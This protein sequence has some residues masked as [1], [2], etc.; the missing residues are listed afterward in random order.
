MDA[1]IK[2][3]KWSRFLIEEEIKDDKDSKLGDYFTIK[4]GIATGNNKFFIFPKEELISLGLP[5]EEF[6]PIL[7]S[8]RYLEQDII[9]PYDN[10][11]PKLNVELFVLDSKL[12]LPEIAVCYPVLYNYLQKGMEAEIHEGHLCKARKIW[13]SQENRVPRK[14][15]CTYIGRKSNS[16]KNPFRF[17]SNHS[18]AIAN[19]SYLFLYPKP[20]LEALISENESFQDD[21]AEIMN[22]I[23][24]HAMIREGRVYGGGMYKLEPKE[25][26]NVPA[27]E[28]TDAIKKL[29][30][31]VK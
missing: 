7:P 24:E 13:Y 14:F 21:I 22:R 12:S 23:T 9:Q 16:G 29:A 31:P 30:K 10:G 11:N 1:L 18:N 28:L 20:E 25:L 3:K 4:R 5:I 6:K 26:A 19:N 27:C 8:P 17:I 15:Y 2:E